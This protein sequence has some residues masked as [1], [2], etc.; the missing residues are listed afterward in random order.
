MAFIWPK[1][2]FGLLYIPKFFINRMGFSRIDGA[3]KIKFSDLQPCLGDLYLSV[4]I[5]LERKCFK[6]YRVFSPE[7]NLTMFPKLLLLNFSYVDDSGDFHSC[8]SLSDAISLDY[9]CGMFYFQ[10][11]LKVKQNDC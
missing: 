10:K 11:N 6:A 2:L 5:G 4:P 9:G 3:P 8:A 7:T 1:P